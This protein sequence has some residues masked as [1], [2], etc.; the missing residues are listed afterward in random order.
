MHEFVCVKLVFLYIVP[1][2]NE[3]NN[4]INWLFEISSE[5]YT[6]IRN[7]NFWFKK[8]QLYIK[9][10]ILINYN[11]NINYYI[12]IILHFSHLYITLFRV[13]KIL[14]DSHKGILPTLSLLGY[15]VRE[16]DVFSRWIEKNLDVAY[17]A[18]FAGHSHFR[19][20]G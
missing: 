19:I 8:Y 1:I 14:S 9:N 11:A 3:T 16:E 13:H 2:Y 5:K 4:Y 15:R 12:F 20:F 7:I 6:H 18:Q 17:S 10:R